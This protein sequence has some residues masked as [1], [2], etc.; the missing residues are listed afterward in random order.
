M[1]ILASKSPRRKE[2][3]KSLNINFKVISPNVKEMHP[4]N[5]S[6]EELPLINAKIKSQFVA[7]NYPNNLVLGADTIVVLNGEILEKPIDN[8]DAI[9]MLMKLSGKIHQVITGVSLNCI[10][11]KIAISFI[12][13]SF[14]TFKKFNQKTAENYVKKVYVIDKA[15]SYAV[16]ECKDMIIE[17]IKGSQTNVKGLPAEKIIETLQTIK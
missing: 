12:E 9:N 1:L 8:N 4:D 16:Q 6:P 10:S 2:I 11:K 3:L 17:E 15:G 14:V 5:H 7:K 13:K